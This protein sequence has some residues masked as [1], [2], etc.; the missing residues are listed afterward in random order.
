V[1]L[2]VAAAFF[3][4]LLDGAIL[5]TSLPLMAEGLGVTPLALTAG[6]TVYLLAAAAVIPTSGWLAD[7]WEARRVFSIAMATFTLASLACGLAQ[8]LGQLVAARAL[9][10]MAAGVMAPVGRTLVLRKAGKSEVMAAIATDR[11]A[12]AAGAGAG[13]AAGGLHQHLRQLALELLHQP[14]RRAAGLV[15]VWRWMPRTPV[16]RPGCDWTG[17]AASCVPAPWCCCCW[18]RS[19]ARKP[20]LT[21]GPGL[22]TGSG[23]GRPGHGLLALRHLRHTP[24]PVVSLAPLQVRSFSIA[25]AAAAPCS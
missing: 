16:P 12:C 11:L 3:M 13:P 10:G 15:A 19:A 14:P 1:A 23:T 25:T 20:G 9:Q 8:S 2:I 18:A 22:A 6:V 21:W 7:R 4:M 24:H 5:N 17:A